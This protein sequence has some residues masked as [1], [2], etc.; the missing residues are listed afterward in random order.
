MERPKSF[1]PTRVEGTRKFD[2]RKAINDLYACA[3]WR[4]YRYKYLAIN[5][6]CYACGGKSEVIDHVEAHR[7][8]EK[9]FWKE[10][11]LIPLCH[12]CH[13]TATALF[14]KPGKPVKEKLQWLAW[15]RAAKNLL[16]TKVKVVPFGRD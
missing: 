16:G 3:K 4:N 7:G 15:S 1:K 13:N 12:K 9:L 10:D 6:T 11:N 2:G 5:P 14:D 8:D